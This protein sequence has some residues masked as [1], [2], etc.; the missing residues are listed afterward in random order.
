MRKTSFRRRNTV[1][2]AGD[3]RIVSDEKDLHGQTLKRK[4]IIEIFKEQ[5]T[6]RDEKTARFFVNRF[7][8]FLDL[9]AEGEYIRSF[10]LAS[11]DSLFSLAHKTFNDC[12]GRLQ[13]IFHQ[14]DC[15]ADMFEDYGFD[16]PL[17]NLVCADTPD[18]NCDNNTPGIPTISYKC[19]LYYVRHPEED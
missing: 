10:K 11:R 19:R 16:I 3:P 17:R 5:T 12:F 1:L 2:Y 7:E 6:E 15:L 18:K 14:L 9:L 4:K 8:M 13:Q